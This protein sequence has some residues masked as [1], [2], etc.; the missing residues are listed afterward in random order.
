M[1]RAQYKDCNHEVMT[2]YV[3]SCPACKHQ[4]IGMKGINASTGQ[5]VWFLGCLCPVPDGIVVMGR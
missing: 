4:R 3:L 1:V 5:T 2:G